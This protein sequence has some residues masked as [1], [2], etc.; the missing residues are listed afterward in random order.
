MIRTTADDKSKHKKE[1]AK[2]AIALAMRS[3]WSEALAANMSI[4]SEFPEDLEA[5]NRLGKAL[6][7]LGRN[8]EAETAFQR[9][10]EISPYNAI[11]K[12]NLSRLGKLGDEDSRSSVKS[13][14]AP[15]VFIEESGKAV[16]TSLVNLA[17]TKLLLK[18][19]P[20]TC[21]PAASASGCVSG[22]DAKRRASRAGRAKA[23]IAADSADK[24]WQPL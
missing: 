20:G 14:G 24:G 11:A 23:G 1:L 9:A 10:L 8:R 13:S 19:A 2:Q 17:S 5:Y 6:T 16:V 22:C 12:K 7:E 3:R 15:K 4:L 21:C 18:M